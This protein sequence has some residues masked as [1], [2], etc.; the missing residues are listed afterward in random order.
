MAQDAAVVVVK[1]V[2]EA[3]FGRQK[4]HFFIGVRDVYTLQDLILA[5]I[6]WQLTV[7]DL[8]RLL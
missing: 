2:I 8:I 1:G 7:Q 4:R 6:H 5:Q 3:E